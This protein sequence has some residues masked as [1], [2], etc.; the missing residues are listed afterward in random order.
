[1]FVPSTEVLGVGVGVGGGVGVVTG[2]TTGTSPTSVVAVEVL[3]AGFGSASFAFTVAVL[4]RA[5]GSNPPVTTTVAVTEPPEGTEPRPHVTTPADWV[6]LPCPELAET[7]CTPA[8]SVS[9][10]VAAVPEVGP[11]F[12]TRKL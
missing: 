10:K 1:M 12:E 4:W 6:Q 5:P 2:A 11:V 9:V 8:G 3:F 7:N